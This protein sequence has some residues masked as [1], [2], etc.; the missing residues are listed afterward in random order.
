MYNKPRRRTIY[1]PSDDT[2]ILTIHPG[3]QSDVSGLEMD[4]DVMQ[5]CSEPL[6]TGSKRA[7]LQ[8]TLRLL[9]ESDD[10]VIIAGT[11]PGKEN[12]APARLNAKSFKV[13]GS[14]AKGVSTFVAAPGRDT[15]LPDRASDCDRRSAKDRA[16][17]PPNSSAT[18]GKVRSKS[19]RPPRKNA[20][21]KTRGE[22]IMNQRNSIYD[23]PERK[24][25]VELNAN[26]PTVSV[27]SR[28][29]APIISVENITKKAK[30]PIL[31]EDV[32]RPAIFE[33][34]LLED[35]QLAIKQLINQLFEA[36]QEGHSTPTLT[37]RETRQSL[38]RFYQG[39]ECSLLHGRIQASLLYGTLSPPNSTRTETSKL[40]HDLGFRQRFVAIWTDSYC[41]EPLLAAAEVV[42]GR[43]ITI[44]LPD[45]LTKG[46][47]QQGMG[48][49]GRKLESFFDS[50]LLRN[51]DALEPQQ[52][53][54]AWCWRRTVLRSLMIIFL[55]ASSFFESFPIFIP[56]CPSGFSTY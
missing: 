13:K 29:A 53:S 6:A 45:K 25:P 23:R 17:A 55:L 30:H 20:K 21:T 49:C 14:R 5:G 15:I 1:V 36:T 24:A 9:Q 8:P 54:S 18:S 33:N 44:V 7:P 28:L 48:P 12:V 26:N 46:Q 31:G 51:E 11:G 32:D 19:L 27:P 2:T 40:R 10:H 4:F 56:L 43:E 52:S 41:V 35:Q 42:I 22:S 39:P 37:H 50:Y 16:V 38:L 47:Q 34:A 3:H